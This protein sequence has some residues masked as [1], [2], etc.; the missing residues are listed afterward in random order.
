[1][2]AEFH[3]MADSAIEIEI[4]GRR[5]K[6]RRPNL[7]AIFGT[8]EARLLSKTIAGI[9]QAADTY[10]LEGADRLQFL[11]DATAAMPKGGELQTMARD[12][13]A[14]AEGTKLLM[15][16]ALERDQP[17]MS[18]E[19]IMHLVMADP[20]GAGDWMAYLT[21]DSKKVPK[22]ATKRKK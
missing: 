8:L 20:D 17:D 14:S 13:L 1:M 18:D 16:S 6:A 22:T 5:L 11:T 19:E 15:R 3:E 10:G 12:G 4:G 2:V 9:K 7:E 21:G